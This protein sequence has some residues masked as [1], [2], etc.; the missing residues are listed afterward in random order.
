[1]GVSAWVIHRNKG[2][3]GEDVD[4]FRPERWLDEDEEKVKTMNRFLSQFGSG[5][6]YTCIGNNIALFEM[7]RLVSAF[8]RR[9]E[10][11]MVSRGG[12]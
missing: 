7:H 1:M 9:F 11:E 12:F 6:G 2:I 4:V 8:I 10:L 3:Y 5:G